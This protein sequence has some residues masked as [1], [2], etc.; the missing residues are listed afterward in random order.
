MY[1][2]VRVKFYSI[3]VWNFN[4]SQ[5]YRGIFLL[6]FTPLGFEIKM[7]QKDVMQKFQLNFTPLGFKML[8]FV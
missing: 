8:C 2:L 6:N 1:V 5:P 4:G 3:G 7:Y